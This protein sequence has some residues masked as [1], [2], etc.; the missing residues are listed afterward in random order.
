MKPIYEP[1]NPAGWDTH[2]T[3]AVDY[4]GTLTSRQD[5]AVNDTAM[6]YVKSMRDLGCTVIL[7][8]SRY[9]E[10]LYDALEQCSKRGL[11]FDGINE[12]PYRK[13]SAKISADVYIDDKANVGGVID[14]EGWIHAIR[15]MAD[16]G[17]YILVNRHR[18]EAEDESG[19]EHGKE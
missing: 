5:G 10:L 19:E 3:I 6:A 7:W 9:G 4:D 16:S 13:S 2:L 18:S 17:A 11:C 15:S 14:W 12:N 8:T 1:I